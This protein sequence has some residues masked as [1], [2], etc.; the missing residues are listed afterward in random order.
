LLF[1][2]TDLQRHFYGVSALAGALYGHFTSYIAPDMFR[3]LIMIYIFLALTAGG[4]GNSYGAVAGAFLVIAILESSRF[5]GDMLPL[6][7]GAQ[8]T[9]LKEITIALVLI[10]ILRFKPSGLIP[11]RLPRHLPGAVPKEP[12]Q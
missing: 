5:L 6:L 12:L 3:P 7:D 9:A 2:V 1:E 10:L 4:T 11:E 8:V